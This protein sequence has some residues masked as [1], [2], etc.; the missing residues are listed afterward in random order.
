MSRELVLIADDSEFDRRVL[1][2]IVRSAGFDVAEA[3]DGLQAY[4]LYE[5]LHPPIVLLDALMPKLDGFEVARRIK[6]SDKG[7]FTSVIFLTSLTEAQELAACVS[8][9]GDDFLSKPYNEIILR[10][11]LEAMSRVQ[12]LHRLEARPKNRDMHAAAE[13]WRPLRSAAA[14][15]LWHAY[16]QGAI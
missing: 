13:P 14:R 16:G 15:L 9:G 11:K 12:Q 1:A 2:A 3:A 10:A 6:A 4:D 5:T 8:A 7:S